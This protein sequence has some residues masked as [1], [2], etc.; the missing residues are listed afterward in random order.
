MGNQADL[1]VPDYLAYLA[2]DDDTRV[3]AVYVEGINMDILDE[4]K[5][6]ERLAKIGYIDGIVTNVPMD[7]GAH[8]NSL[9]DKNRRVI[10]GVEGFC[11][12][13]QKTGV[14]IITHN[15]YASPLT[16]DLMREAKVPI[17]NTSLECSLAMQGLV[18]YAA[19]KNR[20]IG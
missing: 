16:M 7:W 8:T 19:F 11:Q 18:T 14:P 9:A 1:T 4:V 15:L 17:Y 3:I 5:L 20:T 2:G 10:E 13:P 12:I 6:I